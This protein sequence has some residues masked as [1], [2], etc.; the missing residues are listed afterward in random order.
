MSLSGNRD[1]RIN[2]IL[3]KSSN[4]AQEEYK[5]RDDHTNKWYT[6]NQASVLE[7][8]THKLL[9]DFDIQTDRLFSARRPK[10]KEKRTCKIVDFA[11][12]ADHKIK[13]KESEKDKYLGLARELKKIW[14]LK[15]KIIP[16]V[17]G[18]FGT[19]TKG[20]LKWLG[21]LEVRGRVENIQITT[22]LRKAWI[23][24]RVLAIWGNI[25]S[26]KLKW[27]T[28]IKNWYEKLSRSK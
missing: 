26:L 28:I 14:N 6:P 23:P 7:N 1:E 9:W 21:N 25:L 4:L 5:T 8:D 11:Y 3:S 13:L 18:V 19:V 12:P 20:L 2:H 15:V 16:M 27:K 17:I 10:Q 24:R 22:L